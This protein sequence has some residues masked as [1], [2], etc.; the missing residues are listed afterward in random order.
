MAKWDYEAWKEGKL[1]VWKRY[2]QGLISSHADINLGKGV[3]TY[4]GLLGKQKC[5]LPMMLAGPI[6]L[7]L[8]IHDIIVIPRKREIFLGRQGRIFKLSGIRLPR[9][10]PKVGG[11]TGVGRRL[12]ADSIARDVVD[13]LTPRA[14]SV[15]LQQAATRYRHICREVAMKRILDAAALGREISMIDLAHGVSPDWQ[16]KDLV[17]PRIPTVRHAIVFCLVLSLEADMAADLIELAGFI[18][19]KIPI[20]NRASSLAIYHSSVEMLAK[21][22]PAWW[23]QG[24]CTKWQNVGSIERLF[25]A[26][27]CRIM[28]DAWSRDIPASVAAGIVLE[29]KMSDPS[30]EVVARDQEV[31][32]VDWEVEG[33]PEDDEEIPLPS[34]PS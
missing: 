23:T 13:R 25:R 3:G 17:S 8:E 28:N 24:I 34:S 33:E 26:Q 32:S 27:F 22:C 1:W 20:H 15:P 6:D 5:F 31:W 12:W 4:C 18:E 16:S 29:E 7:G 11:L 21:I 9:K 30:L 10:C 2:E 14:I 19:H